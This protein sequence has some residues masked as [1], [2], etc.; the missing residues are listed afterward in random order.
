MPS[1]NG[2]VSL[3]GSGTVDLHPDGQLRG[4]GQLHLHGDQRRRDR[5]GHRHRH[6]H[7]GR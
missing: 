1:P 2:T 6:R 4:S 7:P 3:E 5:N